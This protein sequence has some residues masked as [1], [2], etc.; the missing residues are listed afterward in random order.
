MTPARALF[1]AMFA[2]Q[3]AFLVLAPILP[4]MSREFGVAT[5]TAGQLRLVSGAAGGLAA[6][7]IAPLARR[8]DLR[9]LLTVGLALLA[10]GSFASALAPSF[11]VLAGAQLA[12][13]AGLGIVASAAL[14]AAAEWA[15]PERRARVVSWALLGQPAAWVAGMPVAGAVADIDWR[16]AWLAVP[17]LAAVLAMVAVRRRE[18]DPP[19]SALGAS[20]RHVWRHPT[21][22]GWALGELF[23]FA[24]WGGTL[25]FS[26][27]LFIESY[28]ASAA[29]VG[30]VLAGGAAAYLPGS[31]LVRRHLADAAQPLVVGLGL[32]LAVAVAA[33]GTIRPGVAFSAALFAALVFLAGGRA[34]AGSAIGLDA[35]PEDKMAVTSIRAA[36]TQFGYLLG[37]A[38]AGG[39]LA[40]GGYAALGLT[41]AAMFAA[42]ALAPIA[43]AATSRLRRDRHAGVALGLGRA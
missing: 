33:F 31:F 28:G 13:G 16:L 14:A 23:A 17:F 24:A 18:A 37:A 20:W 32:A 5:A 41:Q 3:A 25:V 27:A 8:L 36:A 39:A 4:E 9:S 12:L 38:V 6:L 7:A 1:L 43:I 29:T 34:L 30:A 10:G 40:A 21:V 26:G 15:A 19:A 2:G 22:A 35:A 42:A 11:W